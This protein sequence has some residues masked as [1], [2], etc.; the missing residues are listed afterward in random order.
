MKT[1]ATACGALALAALLGSA[2]QADPFKFTYTGTIAGASTPGVDGGD[3]YTLT[4]IADNGGSSALGQIWTYDDLQGFTI[5]AGSYSASYSKAWESSVGFQTDA[6]GN[7][8]FS[9][10]YGTSSSSNNSDNFGS[11]TGDSVWGDGTFFDSLGRENSIPTELNDPSRWTVS[12][13]AANGAVPEPASWAMM[14][15]GF[16]LVGGAMRSRRGKAAISF[17]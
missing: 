8:V 14:L 7:V 12:A 13:V 3:T 6:S 5:Q 15:G 16:G 17:A 10:F 11:W 9:A 2:A 1:F 4:V